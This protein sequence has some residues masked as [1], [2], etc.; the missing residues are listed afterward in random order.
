MKDL[1]N[2]VDRAVHHSEGHGQQHSDSTLV[3]KSFNRSPSVDT[4]AP[5][6]PKEL[7]HNDFVK[8][9]E[10]Y[11]PVA[12][13]SVPLHKPEDIDFDKV[14]G[15]KRIKKILVETILWP[16]KVCTILNNAH[17]I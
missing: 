3:C 5:M 8:A 9:L 10:S 17:V 12:L 1:I 15:L 2:V 11:K 7:L 14:G 13:R 16:A 4:I 6:Q